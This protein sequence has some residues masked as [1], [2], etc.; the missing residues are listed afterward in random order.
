MTCVTDLYIIFAIMNAL[1][2]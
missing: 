2:Y 1:A